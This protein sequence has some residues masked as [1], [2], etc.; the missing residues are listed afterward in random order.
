MDA[1]YSCDALAMVSLPAVSSIATHAFLNCTALESVSLPA[2][3]TIGYAAFYGCTDLELVSLPA[4][5]SID[6]YAFGFT[7][8]GDLAVTLGSAANLTPPALGMQM[9][10]GV[11]S[12]SVTVKVPSG[13]TG[14]GTLPFDNDDTTTAN[15][16]NGFRGGGWEESAMTGGTVNSNITLTIETYTP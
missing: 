13:A 7:G 3:T 6:S 12:K 11:T 8:T 15:W 4:A 1:F 5:T 16:G 2:A 10:G 14:Y 9:F